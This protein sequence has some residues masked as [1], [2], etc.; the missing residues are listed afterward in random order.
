MAKLRCNKLVKDPPIHYLASRSINATGA[1]AN[2]DHL[3]LALKLRQLEGTSDV[4]VIRKIGALQVRQLLV[5]R[6]IW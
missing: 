3:K 5:E 2:W 1:D 4:T 6:V